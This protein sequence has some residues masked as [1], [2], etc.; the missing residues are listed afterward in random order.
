[1]KRKALTFALIIVTLVL[2][3]FPTF[4]TK[5]AKAADTDY[6]I[7]KVNHTIEVMY[8]GYIFIN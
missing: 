7:E 3:S 2:I 8:N 1:M 4:M 5:S 6:S